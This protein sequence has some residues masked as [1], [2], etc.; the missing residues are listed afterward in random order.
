MENT[1][2]TSTD[3]HK[4]ALLAYACERDNLK[5][6]FIHREKVR[7]DYHQFED[8]AFALMKVLPLCMGID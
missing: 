5:S 3:E 2:E 1:I 8:G 6:E 7:E 4:R